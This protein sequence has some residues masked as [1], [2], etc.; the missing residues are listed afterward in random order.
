MRTRLPWCRP[1]PFPLD[2]AEPPAVGR[3]RFADG[4]TV[5]IPGYRPYRTLVAGLD[6]HSPASTTAVPLLTPAQLH[7]SGRWAA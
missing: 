4:D 5:E 6:R 1:R 3:H 7:R 2:V